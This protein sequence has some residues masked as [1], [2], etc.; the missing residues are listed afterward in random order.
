VVRRTAAAIA[1]T[2]A[3]LAGC[4][5]DTPGAPDGTVDF[6]V[7][8][9][10]ETG[11]PQSSIRLARDP[12]SGALYVLKFDGDI[13]RWTPGSTAAPVRV[14]TAAD[15]GV[16]LPQGMAFGPDGTLYLVGNEI[17]GLDQVGLVRRGVPAGGDRRQWSTLAR[18]VPFP[19]SNTTFDHMLSGIAVDPDGRTV[20][21][22]SGSRTDHGEIQT[23]GGRFPGLREVPLTALLL[24][25]PASAVDLVLPNDA[26]A[27]APFVFARGLRNSF[28]PAFNA[29]GD[30]IAGD[31]AGD[32]DDNDELNWLREGRHYGFPWRMGTSDTPQQFRGYDPR[33][34]RLLNPLFNAVQSGFF[35]DDPVY[36]PRPSTPLVDPI[37]NLGPDANSFRDPVTGAIQKASD[38]GRPLGTFTTH[39][40]PLGL[41]FDRGNALGGRY[42][43][44]AFI[45]GWTRGDPGGD[46]V[47][48]PIR[49]AGE[50][51]LHLDL[52]KAGESY[53]LRARSVV[54]G[55][56]NP[57][58][59]EIAGGKLYVLEF[60][61]TGTIWEITTPEREPSSG[62]ACT[63]V[64]R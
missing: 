55:F 28:D 54:C 7:R 57:I 2:A 47:A 41:S 46:A 21:V 27:L 14:H 11:G 36:P 34:D 29:A 26:A 5:G 32:R 60:G 50:D 12:A 48:G 35:Y 56:L 63:R 51:L 64:V 16:G 52:A 49:D 25:L 44:S 1:L 19:R 20:Y 31:N 42:R 30:L 61:G 43:G 6:G 23:S 22:S 62:H 24:R 38:L 13:L 15:T 17:L 37:P 33:A 40:S 8:A 59:T 18:T 45:L 10:A 9:V 58:D 3:T 39:R 53:T 4:G